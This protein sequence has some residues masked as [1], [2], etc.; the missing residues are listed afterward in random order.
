MPKVENPLTAQQEATARDNVRRIAESRGIVWSEFA[1]AIDTNRTHLSK[2]LSGRATI[3]GKL[4]KIA[5]HLGVLAADLITTIVQDNPVLNLM[6]SPFGAFPESGEIQLPNCVLRLIPPGLDAPAML[7]GPLLLGPHS[8]TQ[9]HGRLVWC[10]TTDGRRCVR[11]FTPDE[12][13]A[14]IFSLTPNKSISRPMHLTADLVKEMREVLQSN[15]RWE[16]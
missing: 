6:V 16:K 9:I 13:S 8:L 2:I 15:P 14:T 1:E 7:A 11:R 4:P 12:V 3:A 10:E 5:A